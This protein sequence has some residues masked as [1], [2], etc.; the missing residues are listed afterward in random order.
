M[1]VCTYIKNLI[2][3]TVF[4]LLSTSL[5]LSAQTNSPPFSFQYWDSLYS[6]SLKETRDSVDYVMDALLNWTEKNI[7]LQGN[8]YLKYMLA[9][10]FLRYG[11]W[12]K[13]EEYN[14]KAQS[15][16]QNKKGGSLH[17]SCPDILNRTY[18]LEAKLNQKKGNFNQAIFQ[19]TQ[20]IHS[21]KSKVD[22]QRLGCET[23]LGEIYLSHGEY[24]KAY[25]HFELAYNLILDYQLGND[26]AANVLLESSF[27]M[28]EAGLDSLANVNLE[29]VLNIANK[30]KSPEL[31]IDVLC[32]QG[33]NHF[34]AARYDACRKAYQEATELAEK[35]NEFTLL[36]NAKMGLGKLDFKIALNSSP[37]IGKNTL[38]K[39]HFEA[40]ADFAQISGEKK[41]LAQCQVYLGEIH[42][43]TNSIDSA[44][45][46]CNQAY[47]VASVSN[48]INTHLLS[49]HCLKQ[50][51]TSRKEW[52][53]AFQIQE[54][55]NQLKERLGENSLPQ[56]LNSLRFKK[57]FEYLKEQQERERQ[58]LEDEKSWSDRLVSLQWNHICIISILFGTSLL[59]L[60][61]LYWLFN[62]KKQHNKALKS[63][64][65]QLN[66][67][68]S[69]LESSVEELNQTNEML[70]LTN[71]ALNNFATVAAHDLKGPLRS[72]I[73]FSQLLHRSLKDKIGEKE[74]DY[75][76]Y[77][78]NNTR[79]LATLIDD[80]LNFSRLG[81]QM[82]P[83]VEVD[84]NVIIKD[85]IDSFPELIEGTNTQFHIDKLPTVLAN[86][87]LMVQVF[88]NLICNSL[89]FAQ[90]S[91]E[92][93]I[94]ISAFPLKTNRI[95]VSIQDNGIGIPEDQQKQVF[96]L[97][98]RLNAQKEYEGSG[99]GLATCRK[100]VRH[101]GG[102]IMI[103]STEGQETT[104]FFDL[105]LFIKKN[106]ML[107]VITINEF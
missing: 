72:I 4:Y 36:A 22:E 44:Y 92:S 12:D 41:M 40:A 101:Y 68:N 33:H 43:M 50:I 37:S 86:Y 107:H 49:C 58:R 105:P 102:K 48:M 24:L 32:K 54:E 93:K 8:S 29:L 96:E 2:T 61:I 13:A 15:I 94:K 66:S 106:E 85:V 42:L 30:E 62:S 67:S 79:K 59:V 46:L 55:E 45:L 100:I 70:L 69:M 53:S 56:E 76:Q 31:M 71:Q 52:R 26:L 75:F 21:S 65:Y 83:P 77:I 73:S 17:Q 27:L 60:L 82:P 99:V 81:K 35:N 95:Q 64:N 97:F 80:L 1:K 88:Q 39:K 98:T 57:D 78:N 104:V 16:C 14:Q 84:L 25:Q 28:S 87:S 34:I 7:S 91:K 9:N 20:L 74:K 6:K 11:A 5:S 63:L 89:K 38:G 47:E 23:S 51:H 90:K 3:L 19:Y 10:E 18:F 103:S